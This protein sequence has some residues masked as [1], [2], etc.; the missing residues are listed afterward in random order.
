[1]ALR[2][3]DCRAYAR[4]RFDAGMASATV[5]T[6][7][8][9]LRACLQWA[10]DTGLIERAPKVWVPSKGKSRDTVLSREEAIALM[11]AA[12]MGDPHI[13]IFTALLFCTGAR[14]K[15]ITELTWD[16]IDFE[17]GTIDYRTDAK[18]DPM[19]KAYQKGRAKVLM[20]RVAR[21]GLIKAYL[22]RQTEFVIEHGGRRVQNVRAGFANAVRRA[23][24]T[25]N[26]TPH[27][28]RH[29]I[30]S[31][32]QEDAGIQT[33]H[34]AQLV[35]HTD[36]KTTSQH[37]T[38]MSPESLRGVVDTLDRLFGAVP[39]SAVEADNPAQSNEEFRSIMLRLKKGNSL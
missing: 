21:E 33:R 10:E 19:S 32:L 6:E 17:A 28:I 14:H 16:R 3:D 22:G 8:V 26:V 35:G 23:G 2:V 31:W 37:Y 13:G 5:H 38:H 30:V 34:T 15:A 9:R 11:A 36:E 25:K 7:L 18:R 12:K 27:T 20:S 39:T 29:S 1:M 24:I 4:L